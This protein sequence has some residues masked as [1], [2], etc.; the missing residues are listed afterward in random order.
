MFYYCLIYA[1][2][3]GGIVGSTTTQCFIIELFRPQVVT[4]QYLKAQE[5]PLLLNYLDLELWTC[6][7]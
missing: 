7:T 6:S 3:C 2:W 4:V 1:Q 5:I